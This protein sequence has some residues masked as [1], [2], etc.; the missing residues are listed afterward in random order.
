MTDNNKSLTVD[1]FIIS[2]VS[3]PYE[4]L[5]SDKYLSSG[6]NIAMWLTLY[7]LILPLMLLANFLLLSLFST[8]I[9]EPFLGLGLV[10]SIFSMI[11]YVLYIPFFLLNCFIIYKFNY[12]TKPFDKIFSDNSSMLLLPFLL[13][14]IGAMMTAYEGSLFPLIGL[15]VMW[16]AI[17]T[18][19]VRSINQLKHYHEP[20]GT[21]PNTQLYIAVVIALMLAPSIIMLI[22][23]PETLGI[24]Y[25]P[26]IDIFFEG[27]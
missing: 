25:K 20:S 13:Y 12:K 1:I 2:S 22:L 19:I 7:L 26:V 18:Y 4:I 14:S 21:Q 8:I 23:S 11:F 10:S 17:I 24:Y 16:S 27:I 6:Q 15:L 9:S 3:G 5:K